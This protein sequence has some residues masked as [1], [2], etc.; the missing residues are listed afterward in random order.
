MKYEKK[1]LIASTQYNDWQGTIALDDAHK[2]IQSY[3]NHKINDENILGIEAYIM[4]DLAPI[5][6]RL[7]IYTGLVQRDK[8]TG[9]RTDRKH[10]EVKAYKT[11]VTPDEFFKLFK[12]INIKTF[13]NIEARQDTK[14]TI[15][16]EIAI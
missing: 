1:S 7:V 4:S 16:K 5:E 14:L 8:K 15:I 12:R 6:I 10:P 11:N 3:F 9:K 2:S 13:E